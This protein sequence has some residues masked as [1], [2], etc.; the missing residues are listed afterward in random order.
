MGSENNGNNEQKLANLP[1]KKTSITT[2]NA[3]V[4]GQIKQN[5]G[6]KSGNF[7]V[8]KKY[9]SNYK[10]NVE[11]QVVPEDIK[12]ILT[13]VQNLESTPKDVLDL[14]SNILN[15]QAIDSLDKLNKFINEGGIIAKINI[16][17]NNKE[18]NLS[19]KTTSNNNNDVKESLLK[20]HENG[21]QRNNKC[22]QSAKKNKGW[23]GSLIGTSLLAL[24]GWI[25]YGTKKPENTIGQNGQITNLTNIDPYSKQ[26][27]NNTTPIQG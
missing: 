6:D 8:L 18:I 19:S 26:Y 27:F 10:T 13:I 24:A 22:L 21:N 1:P 3:N 16:R 11:N 14:I 4:I 5:N 23:I 12:R 15:N 2:K 17:S 20:K 9:L 7:E 25:L